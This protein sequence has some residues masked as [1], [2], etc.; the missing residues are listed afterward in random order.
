MANFVNVTTYQYNRYLGVTSIIEAEPVD[1]NSDKLTFITIGGELPNGDTLYQVNF[2]GTSSF[3][4]NVAGVSDIGGWVRVNAY[5]RVVQEDGTVLLQYT[6]F[7]TGSSVRVKPDSVAKVSSVGL[8]YSPNGEDTV[9]CFEVQMLDGST[10]IT[11]QD[12][13]DAID[14]F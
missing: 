9:D 8:G 1:V 12:G 14:G 3:L 2:L 13:W 11:D 4:T 5:R 7:R 10:F 6:G